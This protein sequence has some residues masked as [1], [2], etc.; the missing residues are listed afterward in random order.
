[1]A[2]GGKRP[3]AGRKPGKT[4]RLLEMLNDKGTHDKTDY[5][6][7]FMNYL[8]DNYKEDT[9]LMVWMGDHIF[10]KAP[11]ALDITTDGES[12]N[13]PMSDLPNEELEKISQGRA[14]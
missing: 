4:L 11:Q 12:L 3:G 7:E 10:G 9:R 5:L 1:M 14:G 6:A 8:I 13:G 2:R